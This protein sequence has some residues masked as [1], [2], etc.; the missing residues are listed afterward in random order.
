MC[1]ENAFWLFM[2]IQSV[3][4]KAQN[5]F[6]IR[7]QI[8]LFSQK[9][10]KLFSRFYKE[11]EA[12]LLTANVNNF[13]ETYISYLDNISERRYQVC[14]DLLDKWRYLANIIAENFANVNPH[15]RV[16]EWRAIITNQIQI[17]DAE[18]RNNIQGN[19]STLQLS[20]NIYNRVASDIADYVAVGLI[21]QFSI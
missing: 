2:A 20:Y 17:L 16:M 4:F 5:A 14:Q 12:K 11:N 3:I 15:W 21:K 18:I 19:Y 7:N 8:S 13:F 6:V 1:S 9:W 10:G